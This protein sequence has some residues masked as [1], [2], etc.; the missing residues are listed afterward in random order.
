MRDAKHSKDTRT[1]TPSQLVA[2][3]E[4]NTQVMRLRS[5]RDLVPGGYLASFAPVLVDW[6]ASDWAGDSPYVI[7]R[8][9]NYG[10]N[11]LDRTVVLQSV[12][13]PLDGIAFAEVTLVPFG[14]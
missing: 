13:V 7:L 9:V 6:R 11:P 1:L 4:D 2:W 8:N 3:T 12:R 14:V 10:G 5:G